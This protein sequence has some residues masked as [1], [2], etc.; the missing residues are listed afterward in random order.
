MTQNQVQMTLGIRREQFS[1]WE[2]RCA[3]PPKYCQKLLESL[4]NL[5]ILVQP[6]NVWVYTDQ[7]FSEAGC[8]INEDLSSCDVILGV[9][10]VPKEHLLPDKTFIFFSHT[11]KAQ[12]ANM[13][14]LD[15]IL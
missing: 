9:K 1:K 12:K 8:Q 6:S 10:Q 11:I 3:L 14:M 2:R 4:P 13:E 5:I 15:D 7:E